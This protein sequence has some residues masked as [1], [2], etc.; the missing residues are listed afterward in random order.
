MGS[1]PRGPRLLSVRGQWT[2]MEVPPARLHLLIKSPWKKTKTK[3][4]TGHHHPGI[5]WPWLPLGVVKTS[6]CRVSLSLYRGHYI[7]PESSEQR[8]PVALHPEKTLWRN[9]S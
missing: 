8:S 6:L 4:E 1:P 3:S 9:V 5:W 2:M 7:K